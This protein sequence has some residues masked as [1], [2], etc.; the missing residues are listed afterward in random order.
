VPQEPLLFADTVRENIRYGRLSANDDEILAAAKA[1]N[2]HELLA[3]PRGL[4][5]PIGGH[6]GT[7]SGGQR[8]RE[9][10]ARAFHKDA[11]VLILDEPTSALDAQTEVLVMDALEQLFADRT[12]IVVAHR[13]ATV[14][15]A[16]EVLVVREG[17]V[18]QRG[19]HAQLA[20]QQGLYRTLHQARFGRQRGP[21]P[22]VLSREHG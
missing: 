2:L 8:Q 11:P 4:D 13:L 16:H 10:I 7:L 20:R 5:L 17:R 3:D 15:R 12:A 1:A 19:T 14:Y 6:G 18:V 21:Q 22:L 9:A